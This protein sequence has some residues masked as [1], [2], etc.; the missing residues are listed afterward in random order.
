M[1]RD[2]GARDRSQL[3]GLVHRA[4]SELRDWTDAADGDPAVA[5]VELWA[6]V[7]DLLSSCAEQLADEAYLGSAH[8]GRSVGRRDEVEVEV[9]G[10]PWLQVADL[11]GSTAEE[12]HYLVSR[13]DD[14]ASVIEFGDGLHGQRPP[15]GSSIGVRYRSGVGYSS[16]LL[17]Q[18]R[19]IIDTDR[20]QEP[21]RD[22]CGVYRATVLDDADPL[23]QRRLLVRVPDVSADESVWAVACLPMPGAEEVP[24]IGDGVW[25]ALEACDPSRPVWL[26]QRVIN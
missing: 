12:H 7:G 17:Q 23:A 10:K 16:V 20:S 13:R 11:G 26:G 8:R 21:T 4:R 18:G 2:R 6:L 15:P 5:L 22:A 3:D 1:S 9:D 24:A 25:I 19:V 14:G